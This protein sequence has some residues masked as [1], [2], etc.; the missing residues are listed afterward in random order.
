MS[1]EKEKNLR[2][3]TC[4][5][6]LW[7]DGL[8]R[9][10]VNQKDS[11]VNYVLEKNKQNTITTTKNNSKKKTKIQ[12]NTYFLVLCSLSFEMTD[13]WE[14]QPCTNDRAAR[15]FWK[16]NKINKRIFCVLRMFSS[17]NDYLN[18]TSNSSSNEKP[19][20]YKMYI[21][22]ICRSC[23][24]LFFFLIWANALSVCIL[25]LQAY[26]LGGFYWNVF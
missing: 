23:I 19:A 1:K 8:M 3:C 11:F 17:S 24:D 16:N 18:S 5:V 7:N 21:A 10:N 14:M 20:G 9:K 22:I 4:M 6:S 15:L 26:F 13:N 2:W 25:D 12:K